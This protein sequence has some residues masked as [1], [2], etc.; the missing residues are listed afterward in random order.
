MAAHGFREENDDIWRAPAVN[1]LQV[2]GAL[3]SAEMEAMDDAADAAAQKGLLA[4]LLPPPDATPLRARNYR[5]LCPGKGWA[6][7]IRRN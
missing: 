2:Y 3:R 6:R 4:A 1:V 5:L 7:R